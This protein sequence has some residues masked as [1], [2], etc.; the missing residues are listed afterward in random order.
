[1][2]AFDKGMGQELIT[3][4]Y[5]NFYYCGVCFIYAYLSISRESKL[6][7]NNEEIWKYFLTLRTQY[8]YYAPNPNSLKALIP[9]VMVFGDGTLGADE[10]WKAELS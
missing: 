3:K 2:P 4:Y 10:I 6:R 1:M 8:D 7:I 9:S 5:P